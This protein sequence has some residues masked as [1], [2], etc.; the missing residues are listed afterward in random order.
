MKK[1]IFYDEIAP[2]SKEQWKYLAKR[3]KSRWTC[4]NCGNLN[5]ESNSHCKFCG[6]LRKQVEEL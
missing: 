1:W 2:I 3:N 4:M 6:G 5:K